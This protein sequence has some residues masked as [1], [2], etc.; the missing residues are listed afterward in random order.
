M[1]PCV[2]FAKSFF[3]Q[4]SVKIYLTQCYRCSF[5]QISPRYVNEIPGEFQLRII[6]NYLEL[7]SKNS[8]L[9]ILK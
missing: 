7:D 6:F 1:T 4:L 8:M 3:Q 9:E 2:P 5:L